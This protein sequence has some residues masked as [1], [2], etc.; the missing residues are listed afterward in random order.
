M[1]QI[2]W[3]FCLF[4]P[5]PED[6]AKWNIRGLVSK[7]EYIQLTADEPVSFGYVTSKNALGADAWKVKF[8]FQI[9]AQNGNYIGDGLAFWFTRSPI[10][11]GPH[12][13]F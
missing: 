9:N 6:N 13:P 11:P 10:Y 5:F 4:P 12:I 2:D 1:L 7:N 3:D 8:E